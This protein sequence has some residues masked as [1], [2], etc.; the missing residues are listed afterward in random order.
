MKAHKQKKKKKKGGKKMSNE[1]YIVGKLFS[2]F[3]CT[4]MLDGGALWSSSVLTRLHN[5][6]SARESEPVR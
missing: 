5:A 2:F 3:V 1:N 4:L 6:M